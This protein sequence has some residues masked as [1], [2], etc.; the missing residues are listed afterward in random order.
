MIAGEI[1][2]K[3][4]NL[5]QSMWNNG[6][7]NPMTNIMQI[8]Y[9]LFIKMIDDA[10]IKKE[11]QAAKLKISLNEQELLFKSG[12]YINGEVNIPYHDLRW[13]NFKNFYPEKMYDN[14]KT[15]VFPFIKNLKNHHDT[16]KTAFETHMDNAQFEIMKPSILVSLVEDLDQLNIDNR[17]LMGDVYEYLLAKLAINGDN[18]QFRTP[19][20]I[21]KMMVEL[22][23]P[24]IKDVICDPAMGSAGFLVE[25]SKYI[26][27][28]CKGELINQIKNKH[29]N[30]SMFYGF[31][32]DPMMLRI[33][34]MNM[35]LHGVEM[36]IIEYRDSLSEENSETNKFSL[37]LANPPF[38]GSLNLIDISKSLS[39]IVNTKKT[40][41]L[42][43]ALFLRSLQ[44]G[45]RCAS[46]VPVG[47]VN[48]S[49]KAYI[50]IRKNLVENQKLE[51]IIYM[52][53]GVFMPYS[54]VQTAI[55]IFTKGGETDKVWLYNMEADGFSLDKKRTPISDNDIPDI[56]KRYGTELDKDNTPY[57]KSFF[58][59][60]DQIDKSDYSLSWNK[61]RK[62]RIKE[63]VYRK[64]KEILKSLETL[65]K[66]YNEEFQ[67]LKE[68]LLEN[69]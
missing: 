67:K 2:T 63:K 33:G 68:M 42:F 35:T 19:I 15:N 44:Q 52:P 65:E 57:D 21:I 46:I 30:E 17:D 60:K 58:I 3:I 36:P 22:M 39:N 4:D 41:L 55:I 51:A 50:D 34:S 26:Q 14:M 61:Y 11:G 16:R 53:N 31:D 54:G 28:H 18:G 5:W 24:Q 47:V 66:E 40:E 9:L 8:T 45:G 56:I 1:K 43:I 64:P 37:I 25:A 62:I 49:N 6:M 20:H 38:S 23:K 69:D 10:Q 48:N 59:N 32:N 27:N 29:F 13:S 7:A 12:N